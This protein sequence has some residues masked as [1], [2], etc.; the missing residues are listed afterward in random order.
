MFQEGSENKQIIYVTL[1]TMTKVKLF[2]Y[3]MGFIKSMKYWNLHTHSELLTY[4]TN[5]LEAR[6]MQI[7]P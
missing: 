3:F 7:Y 4:Y 5:R 2:M 1:I 6:V